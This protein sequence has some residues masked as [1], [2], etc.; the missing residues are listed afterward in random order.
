MCSNHST[1]QHRTKVSGRHRQHYF[2][3]EFSRSSFGTFHPYQ[4]DK[5]NRSLILLDPYDQKVTRLS[6]CAVIT[7]LSIVVWWSVWIPL[8]LAALVLTAY[9][10]GYRVI[11]SN[12]DDDRKSKLKN[13]DYQPEPVSQDII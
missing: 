12:S 8:T 9:V 11:V 3:N 5:H 13:D 10:M 7:F 6:V 4:T 1:K 2:H